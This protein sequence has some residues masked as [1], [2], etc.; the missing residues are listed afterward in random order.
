MN[1]NRTKDV[2]LTADEIWGQDWADELPADPTGD[3]RKIFKNPSVAAIFQA[4]EAYVHTLARSGTGRSEYVCVDVPLERL[5]VFRGGPYEEIIAEMYEFHSES[6]DGW[7]EDFEDMVVGNNSVDMSVLTSWMK[8]GKFTE[9]DEKLFVWRWLACLGSTENGDVDLGDPPGDLEEHFAP[10]CE[11]MLISI[12]GKL[13]E[14]A[15][16]CGSLS[17]GEGD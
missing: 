15:Q 8:E 11:K 2:L 4:A 5:Q 9:Y 1:E 6:S 16:E 3:V 17:A 14:R 13:I 7:K 10:I 12:I